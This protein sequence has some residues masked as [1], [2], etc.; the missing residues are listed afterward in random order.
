MSYFESL[1]LSKAPNG[2]WDDID[3]VKQFM[4]YVAWK[5]EYK[6]TEDWYKCSR[7]ILEKKY[8]A[9]KLFEKRG[10]IVDILNLVYEGSYKFLPWK[11]EKSPQGFW[12]SM[13]SQKIYMEWLFKQLGYQTEEDWY[14]VTQQDFKDNQGGGL[15]ATY[16]N[17]SPYQ[18]IKALFPENEWLPWKFGQT[19]TRFWNSVTNQ[20]WY[21]EWLFKQLGY[22]TEEDWYKVT[23]Q[24]FKDNQG[25]GLLANYYKDSPY[26]TLKALYPE[27]EWLPWKFGMSYQ[28]FWKSV[29]NQK[30]YIDWLFNQLG[31]QTE[32]DWYK[33]TQ[34]DFNDN[35]GHGLL[36]YY[37]NSPYQTLKS[38][39]PEKEWLP[40]KFGMTYHNFWES[41]ENQKWYMEWLFKQ[42]GYQTEEDWYKVTTKDF[43]DNNGD[44]LLNYYDRSPY[45]N[46]KFLYPE[47]EWLPWKFGMTYLG[48]WESIENQKWY[49]EWLFKQLG[50]QNEDDWYK[51]TAQDFFDNQ[52]NTLLNYYNH[53]P[54]QTIKSLYPEK[55]WL[56][57]KFGRSY[58]NFWNSVDNQKWYMKWLFKHL[59][60]QNEEDWYKISAKDFFDNQGGGLLVTYYNNSPYQTLKF[61]F[62]ETEWLP[63][64]FGSAYKSFWDSVENQKQYMEWLFKHL[65]YQTEEDWY[66]VTNNTFFKN[67]GCRLLKYYGK[68]TN[69]FLTLYPEYP[70][71]LSKFS[72]LKGE[73]I[74]NDF[75]TQNYTNIV[76]G[77]RV[78]WCKNPETD[79]HF[80]FDFCIEDYKI[81]IELDGAQH[82]EQIQDWMDPEETRKRDKYKMEAANTN[83]Y[84]V[85]RLIWDDIYNDKNEWKSKLQDSIKLYETPK[86]IFLSDFYNTFY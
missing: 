36:N 23:Q 62:P 81:I 56:P 49:M 4:R 9:G 38:L 53:S 12:E 2:Y 68:Y 60:Y 82:F 17:G 30:W 52:G 71:Q 79:C 8:K 33:V 26:Q 44:G 3:N 86:N 78:D 46:L 64:K 22:Q 66:K 27:K 59:E 34:Q 83:G 41:I 69:I 15:L 21:M 40:W 72:C 45:Q 67:K 75:L 11:F 65:C 6:T 43:S 7:T 13:G 47:K 29:E 32:K 5:E 19:Y 1:G 39:Y 25:G 48:F 70:W 18:T 85:I 20:K 54:Y 57:W 84:T 51:I 16:Y 10:S 61:L 37:N 80:P 35:K 74:L 63:W 14:K 28:G 42:L 31:Y 77:Y 24:D 50:Y 76:W 58:L 55:E 73:S